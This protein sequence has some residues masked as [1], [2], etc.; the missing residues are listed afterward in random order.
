MN[1]LGLTVHWADDIV[2]GVIW[3][4]VAAAVLLLYER[5]RK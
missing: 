4:M 2:G 1:L 3:G 5:R